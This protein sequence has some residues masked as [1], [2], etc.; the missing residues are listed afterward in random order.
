MP[1]PE[2]FP[3]GLVLAAGEGRRFGGSKLTEPLG[4]STVLGSALAS[5]APLCGRIVVVCGAHAAVA[6]AARAALPAVILAEN[7]DWE[8]GMFSSVL[9]G[10]AVLPSGRALFILPGDIPLVAP[11]TCRALLAHAAAHPE[12]ICIPVY[13]GRR[14]HPVLL[15]A[16]AVARLRAADPA[17]NLRDFLHAE[18][19]AGVPVADP[20]ILR[21]VDTRGDLAGLSG[22]SEPGLGGEPGLTGK[23]GLRVKPG[24]VVNPE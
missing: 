16:A 24:L 6:A 1:A 20:G 22:V 21:D 3:D 12:R 11:A 13:E 18:G 8:K 5:L 17:G 23:P 9:A 4:G 14:G 7:P 19:F 10:L 2:S 15:P